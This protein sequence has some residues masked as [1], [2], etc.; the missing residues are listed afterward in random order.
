MT[1][2]EQHYDLDAESKILKDWVTQLNPNQVHY[3]DTIIQKRWRS[4]INP[5][6]S[7]KYQ[8]V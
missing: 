8:Q 1:A 7:F 6:S 2:A 5:Y 3:F 4:R